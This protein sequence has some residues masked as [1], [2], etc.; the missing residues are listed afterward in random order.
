MSTNRK[1][2]NSFYFLNSSVSI[3]YYIYIFESEI[4]LEIFNKHFK[5]NRHSNQNITK[6][7][8]DFSIRL[9]YFREPARNKVLHSWQ[10]ILMA[11]CE[12]C[13]QRKKILFFCRSI[14]ES[15][16]V[17]CNLKSIE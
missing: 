4:K 11:I 8:C 3:S 10:I 2:Q 15:A 14:T 13:F 1:K 6:Y 5:S 12:C 17:H 7:F 16:R 9:S